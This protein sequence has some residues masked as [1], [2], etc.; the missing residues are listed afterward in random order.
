M[1][2]SELQM[3]Y[4]GE[5]LRAVIEGGRASIEPT[6]AAYRRYATAL[7]REMA[8]LMWGHPCIEHSWYKAAD[9]NVYVLLPWRIVDYWK[10]TR[11]VAA[12]D[13]QLR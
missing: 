7:Q 2:M 8:T 13:H 1:L 5:A 3:R 11:T 9:G 12:Q 4:I 6:P 10:M